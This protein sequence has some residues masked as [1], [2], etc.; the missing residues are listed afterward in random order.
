MK[1]R[2]DILVQ[3]NI[4]DDHIAEYCMNI[5]NDIL[6]PKNL[7]SN[8]TEVFITH[9]AMASQRISKG[10]VVSN[11]DDAILED[12]KTFERFEEVKNLTDIIL[13]T[14]HVIFPQSEIE[15]LWL[16]LCNVFNENGGESV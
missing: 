6:T 8:A 11:M 2:L 3:N 12:I 16:H 4:V 7:V 1:E 15:F 13:E 5:F 9:L 10:D 14:S